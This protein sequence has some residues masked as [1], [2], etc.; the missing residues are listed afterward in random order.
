MTTTALSHAAGSYSPANAARLEPVAPSE[1]MPE[2]DLLRGWAMFGVLWSNLNDWYGTADPVTRLD[3]ALAFTQ[4]WLLESRFYSLLCI[5]FGI[6][7]GIQMV[8]AAERGTTIASTYI[9]RSAALLGIGLVHGLLVW[10]GDILTMYALTS[11]ALLLFRDLTP[12]R[13][14]VAALIIWTFSAFVISRIRLAS[15]WFI[16]VPR[17]PDA[18]GAWIY[19]HGALAQIQAE[20]ALRF[21]DWFGRWALGSY[22]SI[23]AMFLAGTWSVRSGF[24][25]RV[26]A[27]PRITRRVLYIS[28]GLLLLGF[29]VQL[30]GAKIWPPLTGPPPRPW[31][32]QFFYP[33]QIVF[34]LLENPAEAGAVAYGCLILL[35]FQTKRGKRLL[36]P[37]TATGRMAL[38]TYLTQSVV[39]T[40]LFYSFGL[41]W[42]G[43][44]GYTAMFGITISVYALQI[45]ASMWW[46]KRYRFG[47]VEWLWRTLTYGRR[48]A[49]RV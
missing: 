16:M 41:R 25:R 13:Q 28:T 33:R 45:V 44:R 31:T 37:L 6:G 24:L 8:R 5:L 1:R 19:A 34:R 15:G 47:P 29:A 49:I 48:P 7:F 46:L 11:F 9:R 30:W 23:L 43:E 22:F 17:I 42:F 35:A 39:C 18:T 36:A 27:E 14:L 32:W 10:S 4:T 21:A 20:R 12:R 40:F 26:F 2:L 38:T 3:G